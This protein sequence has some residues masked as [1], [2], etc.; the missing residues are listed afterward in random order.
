[1]IA[2]MSVSFV[3]I[4]LD[5]IIP[6]QTPWAAAAE[7]GAL[8]PTVPT[9]FGWMLIFCGASFL[10]LLAAIAMLPWATRQI[11]IVPIALATP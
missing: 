8:L 9:S 11:W 4:M 6:L 5:G 1:M 10:S 7:P 3:K 2:L